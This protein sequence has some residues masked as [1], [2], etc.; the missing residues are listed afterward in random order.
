MSNITKL[1]ILL[2]L[3]SFLPISLMGEPY[4]PP[5]WE[6]VEVIPKPPPKHKKSRSNEVTVEYSRIQKITVYVKSFCSDCD[7]VIAL[8][9]EKGVKYDKQYSFLTLTGIPGVILSNERPPIVIVE[10]T[11][12]TRRKIVGFDESILNAI[13]EPSETSRS[14]DFSLSD[15]DLRGTNTNSRTNSGTDKNPKED[16]F[17]LR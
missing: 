15:F 4:D 16:S 17:D 11:D 1:H 13:F 2:V 6:S 5:P 10:Y 8:L 9:N 12:G 3:L 7:K 14:D